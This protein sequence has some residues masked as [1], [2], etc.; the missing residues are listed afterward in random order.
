M[1]EHRRVG[2]HEGGMEMRQVGRAGGQLD[3]LGGVDQRGLEEHR[4][5][6]VLR[7]IGKMLAHEG[8]IIA[9]FVT[10]DDRSTIFLQ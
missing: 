2:R 4:T 3:L 10:E 5:C 6:D 9:K 7:R 8:I 1:V